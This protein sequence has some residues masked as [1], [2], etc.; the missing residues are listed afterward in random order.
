VYAS[1]AAVPVMLKEPKWKTTPM[2]F[3]AVCRT[4]AN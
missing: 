3:A 4:S 1:S 2:A